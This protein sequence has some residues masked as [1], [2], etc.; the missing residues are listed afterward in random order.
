MSTR[1][2]NSIIVP[3]EV[4]PVSAS[5]IFDAEAVTAALQDLTEQLSKLDGAIG[6]I[7]ASAFPDYNPL[8][9]PTRDASRLPA[10]IDFTST[11][12]SN[13]VVVFDTLEFGP[14]D[15]NTNYQ[16]DYTLEIT[17]GNT[18]ILSLPF[19]S[20][21]TGVTAL[22]RLD[23][24]ITEGSN[25]AGLWWLSASPGGPT[26]P[27]NSY[28]YDRALGGSISF[29]GESYYIESSD[30]MAANVDLYYNT[31]EIRPDKPYW[32]N[33]THAL[34]H[35]LFNTSGKL[36]PNIEICPSRTQTII[37]IQGITESWEE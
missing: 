29:D 16:N 1:P 17:S 10:D 15:A 24:N 28:I 18:E 32:I 36:K 19:T 13:S 21:N 8:F 4:Q 31:G 14:A 33:F 23:L 25:E 5:D 30:A 6:S 7:E 3:K 20:A 12:Y 27:L 9:Q 37:Y 22:Q 26:I 35:G 2:D 11:P 34:D